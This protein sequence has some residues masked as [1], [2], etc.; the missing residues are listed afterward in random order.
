[1]FFPFLDTASSAK[2]SNVALSPYL[3]FM[4]F[5]MACSSLFITSSSSSA[6]ISSGV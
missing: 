6:S 4:A 1:L 2:L 5:D 3:D